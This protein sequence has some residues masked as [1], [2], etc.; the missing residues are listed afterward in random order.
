MGREDERVKDVSKNKSQRNR[1]QSMKSYVE[2]EKQ[3]YQSRLL[4]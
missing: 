2:I 1:G 4:S 3:L